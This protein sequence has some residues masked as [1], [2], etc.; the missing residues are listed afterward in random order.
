MDRVASSLRGLLKLFTALE[1]ID[2]RR[3][4]VVLAAV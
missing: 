2:P 3:V 4:T 1:M